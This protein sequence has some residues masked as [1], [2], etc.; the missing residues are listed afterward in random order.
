MSPALTPTITS[1]DAGGGEGEASEGHG[2]TE[3]N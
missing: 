1:P 3:R 2:K